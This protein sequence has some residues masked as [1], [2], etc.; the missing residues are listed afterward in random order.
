MLRFL[1]QSEPEPNIVKIEDEISDFKN[2]LYGFI[3]SFF[4][5]LVIYAFLEAR[6]K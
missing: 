5:G 4:A 3:G 6:G 1:S 2:F